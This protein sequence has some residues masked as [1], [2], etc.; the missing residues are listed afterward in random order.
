MKLPVI[1]LA[2]AAAVPSG[3]SAAEPTTEQEFD[4]VVASLCEEEG[5][6][7]VEETGR[8]KEKFLVLCGE[9]SVRDNPEACKLLLLDM[10]LSR[11]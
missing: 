9:P 6:E 2:L 10:V 8:F 3:E 1:A 5:P 11:L 4:L 7:C